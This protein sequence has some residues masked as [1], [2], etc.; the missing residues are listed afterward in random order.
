MVGC[1]EKCI[2]HTREKCQYVC[3]IPK[4]ARRKVKGKLGKSGSISSYATMHCGWN[5]LQNFLFLLNF[6]QHFQNFS[7][8]FPQNFPQTLSFLASVSKELSKLLNHSLIAPIVAKLCTFWWD[9]P[10]VKWPPRSRG[11]PPHFFT[12]F[13]HFERHTPY[14]MDDISAKKNSNRLRFSFR[15][16]NFLYSTRWKH[17]HTA[18]K[19]QKKALGSSI[20]NKSKNVKPSNHLNANRDL[21]EFRLKSEFIWSFHV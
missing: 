1:F 19:P 4:L 17:S 9:N 18:R 2:A 8:N 12:G 15:A 16:Y 5:S 11:Q 10:F 7:S 14:K 3:E 13:S 21:L 6:P 20:K